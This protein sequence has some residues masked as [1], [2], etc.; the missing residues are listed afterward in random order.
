MIGPEERTR[1]LWE[2]LSGWKEVYTRENPQEAMH[3]WR[4]FSAI[5]KN[6]YMH[7]TNAVCIR[8]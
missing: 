7:M 5:S 8:D 4:L 3:K 2:T 1:D 6:V